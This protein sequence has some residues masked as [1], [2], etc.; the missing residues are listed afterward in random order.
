MQLGDVVTSQHRSPAVQEAV[1][2]PKTGLDQGVP[3]LRPAHPV[4]AQPPQALK[5]L[6]GR[7]GG[8]AEECIGP[9]GGAEDGAQAMLDVGDRGTAVPDDEGQAYR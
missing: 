6:D 2:E 7:P 9:D 3:R 1:T 4:H 5:G 8:G